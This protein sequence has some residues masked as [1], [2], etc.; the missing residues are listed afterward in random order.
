MTIYNPKIVEQFELLLKKAINDLHLSQN[1][2][3]EQVNLFRINALK[4]IN[5]IL[6]KYPSKINNGDE[7]KNIPGIG[8][9][10][11][12]RLNEIIDNGFLKELDNYDTKK[13]HNN[14][15][16]ELEKV[17]GV[18]RKKAME[19]INKYNIKNIKDLKKRAQKLDLP[20]AIKIGLKYIDTYKQNIPRSE[21]LE[22]DM[23]IQ[24]QLYKIDVDLYGIICGSYRRQ[25]L[26]S[27]DID[28]LIVHPKIRTQIDLK[29]SFENIK[30]HFLYKLVNHLIQLGFI[31][32]T[33]TGTETLSKFM[34]YCRIGNNPYRRIDIRF[35]PYESLYYSQLFFTGSGEFNKRMRRIAMDLGYKLSEY[36][37]FDLE[38]GKSIPADSEK[39]IF[40][41]L[42]MQYVE[43]KDRSIGTKTKY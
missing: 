5:D 31:T 23:F 17:F 40:D 33:L 22:I 27:N 32:D 34:G 35:I 15:V 38:T 12:S 26:T 28:L 4:K 42:G 37:L 25:N 21:V 8:K 43:P 14:S 20:V 10:T 41:K 3:E 7:L 24:Q 9:S 1:K 11:I 16:D 36:G 6:K 39:A 19:L 18:G 29:R 2:K 13:M 30:Q